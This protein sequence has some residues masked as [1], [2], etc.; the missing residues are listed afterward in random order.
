M[1]IPASDIK[2]SG[3][4]PALYDEYLVPLIFEAYAAET[5]PRVAALAPSRVLETAAGTGVVTRAMARILPRSVELIATDLNQPMLDRAA[6]IGTER[7]VQ[8]QQADAMKLP[9][10]DG[11]FDAV[12]CQFGAMFFP[13]RSAAYAE[14]R[15]VLRPGGAF[16]FAV[17]DRIE[18][19]EFADV[20]SQALAKLFPS[21]PPRFMERVPHGYYDRQ[22]IE[23][24]LAN[25]GFAPSPGFETIA[26]RSR[27]PSP[28]VAAFAYCE[29]TPMR[30]EIEG[31]AGS[32][33]EATAICEE[34]LAR[35]FGTGPIDG[36]IQAHIITARR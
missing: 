14:T 24:D 25:A 30:N 33:T 7:P 16:V 26:A 32:L 29:G 35:R 15:R 27:A 21:D 13:D 10:E 23:R 5:A 8:W 19:N 28:H 6:A 11:S 3:S 12:V 36:K 4:I 2:F 1:A 9:F 22:V 18:D 34:A 17:W 20:A 31:R